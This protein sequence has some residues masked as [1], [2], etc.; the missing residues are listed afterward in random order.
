MDA[1]GGPSFRRSY[2]LLRPGGRLIAFGA[3]A[4]VSGDK[5]NLVTAARTALRM[6]R[7]NMIKQMSDSKAVIGLNLKRLWDEH[8]TMEPWVKPLTPLIEDGTIHPVVGGRLH[9]RARR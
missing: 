8:G 4:V 1:I 9:L 6:P 3:S 5:R 2:N 7:F